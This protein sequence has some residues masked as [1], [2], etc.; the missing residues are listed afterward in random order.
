[1][2]QLKEAEDRLSATVSSKEAVISDLQE[3]VRDLM[4]ALDAR[5]RDDLRDGTVIIGEAAEPPPPAR[6]HGRRSTGG[7]K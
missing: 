6:G 1:M 2:R 7:R 4:L 5:Q 3:Q